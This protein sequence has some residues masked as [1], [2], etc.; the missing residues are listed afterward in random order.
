[1][2]REDCAIKCYYSLERTCVERIVLL[3]VIT[4][5]SV[6][7]SRGC[8]IKC[9]YSLER[10]CIERIVLLSVITVSSVRA[11]RGLCY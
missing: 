8:A 2:R 6:R 5:W 11:S 4:V 1:M 10:T 3:S 7:A 9:Y